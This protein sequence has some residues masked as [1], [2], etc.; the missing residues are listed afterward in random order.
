MLDNTSVPGGSA[1]ETKATSLGALPG[2]TWLTVQ[3][4]AAQ[5]L[6]RGRA[7]RA[8][9][10]A[11]IGLVGFADR[12]RLIWHV[13]RDDDPFADWWLIRIHDGLKRVRDALQ[14]DQAAL[15]H[16]LTAVEG[17]DVAVAQAP[18]PYRVRLQFVNPYAYQDAQRLAEFDRLVRSALTAR[19][20]GRL[21][22]TDARHRV[23]SCAQR[24]RG[25]FALPPGYRFDARTRA[26]L[27]QF[28]ERFDQAWSRMGKIPE[29]ILSGERRAPWAPPRATETPAVVDAIADNTPEQETDDAITRT[30]E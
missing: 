19:H 7:A 3:T 30:P 29:A 14:R 2:E 5:Q 27:K 20:V 6:I 11:I 12:L 4:R 15:D 24:L 28:P 10:P 18:K 22:E 16:Y 21:D 17:L 25:L 8:D 23:G 1:G 13:A 26:L 9:K